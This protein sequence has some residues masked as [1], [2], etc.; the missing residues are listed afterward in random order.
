MRIEGY[1]FL[2]YLAML[3]QLASEPAN[4]KLRYVLADLGKP[5]IAESIPDSHD[6]PDFGNAT[7]NKGLL[8]AV[9][10]LRALAQ[11]NTLPAIQLN[12]RTLAGFLSIKS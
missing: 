1:K 2:N 4:E 5:V 11:Q 3:G 9:G 7:M 12:A 6:P 10:T 8:F